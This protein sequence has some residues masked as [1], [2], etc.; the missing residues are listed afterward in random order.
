MACCDPVL[1][2]LL[3]EFVADGQP[4]T[5]PYRALRDHLA[6]CSACRGQAARLSIVHEALRAWPMA[7][8]PEA[9]PARIIAL[10]ADEKGPLQAWH[11]LP[12]SIWVPAVTALAAMLVV[13]LALP[14]QIVPA[15]AGGQIGAAAAQWPLTLA[16]RGARVQADLDPHAVAALW[17]GLFVSLGGVGVTMALRAWGEPYD[18][19]VDCLRRAVTDTAG[20]LVRL[21]RRA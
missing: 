2:D 12:W 21:A 17:A 16:E 5:R 14:G 13:L 7:T 11:A 10:L 3:A 9:L 8:P 1:A 15:E 4:S 18:R 19:Q 6:T 20:R